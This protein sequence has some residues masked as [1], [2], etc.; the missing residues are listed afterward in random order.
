MWNFILSFDIKT[1]LRK[2]ETVLHAHTHMY[3]L[4]SSLLQY[5]C[6]LLFLTGH[7]CFQRTVTTSG[8]YC[9]RLQQRSKHLYYYDCYVF[10]VLSV[11]L[12]V[13]CCCSEWKLNL[14]ETAPLPT[15]V[16]HIWYGTWLIH[17][18]HVA[19]IVILVQLLFHTVYSSCIIVVMILNVI[20]IVLAIHNSQSVV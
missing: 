16:I 9:S 5:Y 10:L 14:A 7:V 13:H 17:Q 11:L 15:H 8:Q 18:L 20:F 6:S 12:H 1:T 2:Q 3:C 4:M 19:C